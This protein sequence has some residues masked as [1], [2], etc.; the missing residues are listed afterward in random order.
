MLAPEQMRRTEKPAAY[1]ENATGVAGGRSGRRLGSAAGDGGHIGGHG[2][3]VGPVEEP[4][5]H[6]ARARAAAPD[7]RPHALLVERREVVE[8]G[9]GDPVGLDRLE[10]VAALAVLDEEVLAVLELPGHL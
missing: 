2:V 5:R 6:A 10:R 4:G 1:G 9:P 8:V 3:R 7:G